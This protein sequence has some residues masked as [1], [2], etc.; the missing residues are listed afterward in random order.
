MYRFAGSLA[1]DNLSLQQDLEHLLSTV[2]DLTLNIQQTNCENL[3]MRLQLRNSCSDVV[4]GRSHTKLPSLR[5]EMHS[6]KS[7]TFK[8]EQ[9][10]FDS[11]HLQDLLTSSQ[12]R[13]ESLCSL[14]AKFVP[15]EQSAASVEHA[16]NLIFGRLQSSSIPFV[17]TS[18][19]PDSKSSLQF[20]DGMEFNASL[21]GPQA[22]AEAPEEC[23]LVAEVN[24]SK[25]SAQIEIQSYRDLVS[26]YE[27]EL[28]AAWSREAE[29][30]KQLRSNGAASSN[31]RWNHDWAS[32]FQPQSFSSSFDS[33]PVSRNAPMKMPALHSNDVLRETTIPSSND[34]FDHVFNLHVDE[35]FPLLILQIN[36]H[37]D[38]HQRLNQMMEAS[39]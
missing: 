3:S 15:F 21:A 34:F 36:S 25:H 29:L 27:N 5:N 10:Q 23:S 6:C 9:S 19:S 18:D 39:V 30:H 31:K 38:N 32:I 28:N 22:A 2:A 37:H 14:L 8:V 7:K 16:A 26:T 11:S 35:L 12:M 33:P 13:C 24:H 20:Q 4:T 17:D 1:Q